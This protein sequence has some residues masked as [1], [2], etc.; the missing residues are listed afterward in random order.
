MMSWGSVAHTPCSL[1]GA[2]G[3]GFA[4]SSWQDSQWM[5]HGT[6]E[7]VKASQELTQLKM[8]LQLE[9]EAL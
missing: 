4:Q 7:R 9:L 8:S 2:Q 5:C 6:C 3:L 1:R